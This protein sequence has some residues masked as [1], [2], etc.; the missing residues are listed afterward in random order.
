ML[1]ITKQSFFKMPS[2]DFDSSIT[3][4]KRFFANPI[5]RMD[6]SFQKVS[7]NYKYTLWN[8]HDFSSFKIH[9]Q[10]GLKLMWVPECLQIFWTFRNQKKLNKWKVKW[11]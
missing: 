8:E 7:N 11:I 1:G 6:V 5:E 9:K 3:E 2:S 10:E 4:R